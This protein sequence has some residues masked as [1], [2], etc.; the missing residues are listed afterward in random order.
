[1]ADNRAAE[2]ALDISEPQVLVAF[3]QDPITWHHR[4]LLRRLQ[5]ARWI[6][7]TPDHDIEQIDLGQMR[8]LALP[9]AGRV[10]AEAAGNCYLFDPLVGNELQ[11]L[12]ANAERLAIVLGAAPAAA[13][14]HPDT[15]PPHGAW[16]CARAAADCCGVRAG[17]RQQH[18]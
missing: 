11:Q 8:L 15:C 4:V 18:G 9:R 10:P 7:S 5:D 3:D 16:V 13:A 2:I 14:P 1:M 12:R 17:P 6:V